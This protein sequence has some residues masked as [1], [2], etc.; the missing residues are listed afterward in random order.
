MFKWNNEHK[1]LC[2]NA[3]I[4]NS[5]NLKSKLENIDIT[6]KEN[7]DACAN[8]FTECFTNIM[9]PFFKKKSRV[10]STFNH[11]NNGS[12]S[13]KPW[14]DNQCTE[15]YIKYC[16]ALYTFNRKK[17]YVDNTELNYV[18]KIYKVYEL[19]CKRIYKRQEGDMLNRLKKDNPQQFY[20]LF[21]RKKQQSTC[22]LSV[23]EWPF[24]LKGWGLCFFSKKNILIP[25]VA[26]KN[27]LIL[28]EEKK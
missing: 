9:S 7:M 17:S 2:Y 13:D 18:K 19:K 3:R 15:L 25:N 20:S 8:N 6:S 27:I 5:E 1:G 24:N 14:I 4:V 28:V 22:N 16:R 26:E 21:R 10:R 11:N 23:R 12:T